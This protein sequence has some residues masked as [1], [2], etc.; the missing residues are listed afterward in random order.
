[1]IEDIDMEDLGAKG[2]RFTR[3]TNRKDEEKVS[4]RIDRVHINMVWSTLDMNIK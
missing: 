4:E 1:M 3:S 2:S